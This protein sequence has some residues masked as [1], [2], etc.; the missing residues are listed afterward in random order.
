MIPT[1]TYRSSVKPT[2]PV[3]ADEIEKAY[4]EV[5]ESFSLAI[6]YK[7]NDYEIHFRNGPK[8]VAVLTKAGLKWSGKRGEFDELFQEE[9]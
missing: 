8:T 6:A 5:K 1:I 2:I 9:S 7:I 4:D 3:Y